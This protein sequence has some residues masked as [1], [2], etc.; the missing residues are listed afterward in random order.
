MFSILEQLAQVRT[1]STLATRATLLARSEHWKAS[2][3][4]AKAKRAAAPKKSAQADKAI[5]YLRSHK[6]T[7][8]TPRALI[9][10]CDLTVTN[11]SLQRSLHR[12][13]AKGVICEL[14]R[15]GG[16]RTWEF[17]ADGRRESAGRT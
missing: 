6:G 1:S 11:D 12:A 14:Q 5:A 9:E 7:H 8:M 17:W 15:P 16:K 3:E 4:A 13:A 2:N 10:A